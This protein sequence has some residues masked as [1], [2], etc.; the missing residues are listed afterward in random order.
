[1]ERAGKKTRDI[2]FFSEKNAEC[3]PAL[4]HSKRLRQISGKAALGREL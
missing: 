3:L 4:P 2:Q 1:M